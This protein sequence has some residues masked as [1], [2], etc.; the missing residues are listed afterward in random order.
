MRLKKFFIMGLLA[1]VF[2][3]SVA[4]GVSQL[5]S[6]RYDHNTTLNTTSNYH[7]ARYVNTP[8]DAYVT[9]NNTQRVGGGW[10]YNRYEVSY[11]YYSRS[12]NRYY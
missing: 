9:S 5:K 7:G 6:Y 8:N 1:L 4:F 2:L 3:P 10:N 12:A 11:T